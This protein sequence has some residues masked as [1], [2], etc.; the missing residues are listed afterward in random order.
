MSASSATTP[1]GG[2]PMLALD[3][4]S[5]TFR[6]DAG[7]VHAV[8]EVSF[9]VAPGEIV[10]V[11]G[12]SGSGKSVSSR[13][14]LGL[15]P[16]TATV[17]GLARLDGVEL[18]GLGGE[19][20]RRIRG[21]RIAMIFQ[22]PATSLDPVRTVGWQVMEA[23]RAHRRMSRRAAHQ[24][25]VELLDL[26]GIPDPERRVHSYPHQLSGGQK[27]RVMIAI[28]I[29]CEPEL[30]IADEPTT[31]LDVTVQAAILDLL[32][33]LRDR[34]GTGIVLITHNMGVVADL[35][36][37]VVVMYRGQV[38]EQAPV[39]Q[40]FAAPA[41]PYTQ[42]LLAAVPYLGQGR[43]G[44]DAGAAPTSPAGTT[45]PDSL[46]GAGHE[47]PAARVTS[48]T[49]SGGTGREAAS[50]S[51]TPALEVRDLVVEFPGRLGS[52][53]VRAVEGV[54]LT[55]AP[56]RV[57]GLVGESGSGKTTV[58]RTVVGLVPA[59]SGSI[60]VF[61]TDLRTAS[62][63]TLRDLR[64]RFGFVFQDPAASLNPRASVGACIAE[65]LS[66]H[67]V[68][69]DASRHKRVAEL[70]EAVELPAAFAKRYPHELSGG[71]RQRVSLARALVLGPDLLIA[72]EPTSALDVSVQATVLHLFQELQREMG[73]ACLF[74]SH[75]LAVVDI[76]AHDVAVMSL[77][78]L[79][80]V[81]TTAEVLSAP[82]HPYTRA[83]LAAVPVPD[84]AAQR[85]RREVRAALL[86]AGSVAS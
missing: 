15:L 10:A 3:H 28:A 22:E 33:G 50:S 7:P 45:T 34:L 13:A 35:A 83:L 9:D 56:G 69:T 58:G 70:L 42:R 14:L 62:P 63:H 78:K 17:G 54:S 43:S 23:L 84:P 53:R 5:V 71:Q 66:V 29:S 68:G 82:Q 57:L 12:E 64:R 74:I 73:F 72:D 2:T 21:D 37:R 65:P 76:V 86:A 75:D 61:G 40:L 11:V 36:D 30:I 47:A 18:T 6:S 60:D 46:A 51:G 27:Q 24:R 41:H 20:M 52:P 8:R 48:F 25:A 1:D 59:T 49:G 4:L 32:R 67:K 39:A 77:G 44:I 19:S 38:V 55:I 85:E 16:G 79:V 81:G 31:A 26:V 80:E